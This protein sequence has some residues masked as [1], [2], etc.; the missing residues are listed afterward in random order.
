M[1]EEALG[2]GNMTA[3]ARVGDTV[4]RTSG[5][6]TATVHR[7]L[8]HVRKRDLL[9]APEPLGFDERGREIL[10]FIPGDVPHDMPAWVWSGVALGDVARAL[11]SWH[12]ATVGFDL[13]GAVWNLP[14]RTPHE[15]IC[16]NDFAPYNCVFRA[17]RFAGAIDF[18]MCAPGPRLWDIAYTAY[19]FIPLLPPP[20]AGAGERSPFTAAAAMDRLDVFLDAYAAGSSLGRYER[21]AVLAAAIERL[22]AIAKWTADHVQ[23]TGALALQHHA[24]MY[25]AHA[26]WLRTWSK[27]P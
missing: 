8:A 13:T 6:W 22:N 3:V 1:Q 15:V 14:A 10:S 27:T 5:A 16:H 23:T 2:G 7:L 17:G 24:V 20:D 25:Q 11:R 18:D 26:Q 19:R 12:D 4:R 9:W 21:A